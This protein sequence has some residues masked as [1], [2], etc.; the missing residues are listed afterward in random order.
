M[1]AIEILQ[2]FQERLKLAALY[3]HNTGWIDDEADVRINN[4]GELYLFVYS[5]EKLQEDFSMSDKGVI[6]KGT[7]VK[8]TIHINL[9]GD[10]KVDKH[11]YLSEDDTLLYSS[12]LYLN[13]EEDENVES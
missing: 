11:I 1:T 10:M 13:K 3:L 5:T 12:Q 7:E 4:E 2:K 6:P 8:A 9:F